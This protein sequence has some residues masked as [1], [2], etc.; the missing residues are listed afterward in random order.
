MSLAKTIIF[1][2]DQDVV[3][4]LYR[5]PDLKIDEIDEYGFT[6]LIQ[7]AIVNSISKAKI[8]LNA[9]ANVNFQDLTGRTALHWAS[10]N[11]NYQLCQLLI[12]YGANPNAYTYAGQPILAMPLLR[13][14]NKI[15]NLL[16]DAGG[17]LDFAQDFINAKVLGHRFELQG[18]V[19]IVNTENTFIE[20]ELEGF[21][22][23]FSLEI[24]INSLTEFHKNFGGKHL[25][26]YFTHLDKIISA[27]Q[28][29]SELIKYQHYLT[30]IKDYDKRINHLLRA[31]PL[32][33]PIAFDGHAIS[34][35]KFSE[36]LIR[37]DRGEFGRKNGAVIFYDVT[38]QAITTSFCKNLLY[39][40]QSK[41]FINDGLINYLGLDPK[42]QLPISLQIAG[43][44]SWA[45]IEAI[46]PALMFLFL[47]EEQGIKSIESSA[48][49][50][51]IFYNDW[52]EWDKERSIYFCAKSFYEASPARKASK[53]ALLAAIFF[54]ACDYENNLDPQKANKIME[55]LTIPEYEYILK[56]YY[57]VFSKDQKNVNLK[58]M[59]NFLDDYRKN[60]EFT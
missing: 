18:R 44:C 28:V 60:I 17:N 58:N 31:E 40:R 12:E 16:I 45:N 41:E 32:V 35:I 49:E 54:Q 2:T 27:L 21:Y 39:K 53:A 47:L 43:N 3:N 30:D 10:E 59:L 46:I 1:K 33:L 25:R 23:E 51:L 42:F 9:K 50:A 24:L 8:I 48:Q 56:A 52:V 20:V 38:Q 36:M 29:A 11:G 22:L 5:S 19:D 13:K 4:A 37:C 6:P 26:K 7:T 57:T 15:V 55:I 34:L 14:N